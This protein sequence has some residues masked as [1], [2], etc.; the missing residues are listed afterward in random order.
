MSTPAL[1]SPIFR[2][3]VINTGIVLDDTNFPLEVF[4]KMIQD[5]V[6]DLKETMSFPVDYTGSAVLFAVSTALG[7]THFIRFKK[8]W[9]CNSIVYVALSGNAGD[10]KTHPMEWILK[11]LKERDKQS[12]MKFSSEWKEYQKELKQDLPEE[13]IIP[14]ES[15]HLLNNTTTEVIPKIHSENRRGLGY[16][17]DEISNFI[18][19]FGRYNKGNDVPVWLSGWSGKRYRRDTLGDRVPAGFYDH[20]VSIIGSIQKQLAYDFLKGK[21]NV[22]GFFERWLFAMPLKSEFPFENDIELNEDTLDNWDKILSKI[23]DLPFDADSLPVILEY[24]PDA[25]KHYIAW[26]NEC[27][28]YIRSQ[29]NDETLGKI[30]KKVQTYCKRFCLIFEC[31]KWACGE[32]NKEEISISSVESAIKLTEYFRKNALTIYKEFEQKTETKNYKKALFYDSIPETFR[33][34][35]AVKIGKEIGIGERSIYTYLKDN[36]MFEKLGHSQYKRVS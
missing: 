34:I 9:I 3:G 1:N 28:L 10:N 16:Y 8:G 13:P 31:L 35:E 7:N 15:R 5:I 11:P 19:N 29:N 30:Q 6:L 24:S 36:K 14:V 25:K 32:S 23:I 17:S 26:Q 33:T 4:P 18:D 27:T 12:E 21:Q 20:F 2:E 22:N